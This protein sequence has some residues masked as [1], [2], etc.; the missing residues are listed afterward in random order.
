MG[1]DR[2]PGLPAAVSWRGGG[3]LGRVGE[4]KHPFQLQRPSTPR[5]VG[6]SLMG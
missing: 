4:E 5:V 6:T 1:V 3:D 2:K